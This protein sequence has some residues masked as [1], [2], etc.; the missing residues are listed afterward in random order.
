MLRGERVGRDQP[1]G[2]HLVRVFSEG[3]V[4][5]VEEPER[6]GVG[7]VFAEQLLEDLDGSPRS[8]GHLVTGGLRKG[9][10]AGIRRGL[11]DAV[12]L[13]AQAEEGNGARELEV[14]E[15]LGRQ[16]MRARGQHS[17]HLEIN[18]QGLV[19]SA[20]AHGLAREVVTDAELVVGVGDAR[21]GGG[22][23]FDGLVV[24][25]DGGAGDAVRVEK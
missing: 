24:E 23:R 7:G 2:R 8:P 20:R 13:L 12:F 5:D 21:E 9:E 16:G 4:G 3:H 19:G 18:V 22:E 6:A 11:A 10:E 25:K 14:E 1:V 17:V 15:R